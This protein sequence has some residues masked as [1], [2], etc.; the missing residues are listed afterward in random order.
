MRM[1]PHACRAQ[2]V[3]H[4]ASCLSRWRWLRLPTQ[5]GPPTCASAYSCTMWCQVGTRCLPL[6]LPLSRP[7][8]PALA[9]GLAQNRGLCFHS[10]GLVL[11]LPTPSQPVGHSRRAGQHVCKASM[12]L[13]SKQSRGPT[14]GHRVPHLPP[15]ATS[16]SVSVPVFHPLSCC[17]LPSMPPACCGADGNTLGQASEAGSTLWALDR[18]AVCVAC[19]RPAVR[20]PAG[21]H[22]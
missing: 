6:P 20:S 5:P 3:H 9:L 2:R 15:S 13:I 21:T 7:P 8:P 11:S 16:T 12:C 18:T 19:P 4:L 22:D 14:A 17:A 10:L 1:P